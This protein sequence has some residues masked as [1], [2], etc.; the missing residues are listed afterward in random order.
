M[1][2][3]GKFW[4]KLN[5]TFAVWLGFYLYVCAFAFFV[6]LV[7]LPY[8][9]PSLH[10]GNGLMWGGD[11]LNFHDVAVEMHNLVKEKGWSAW[12]LRPGGR[13]AVESGIASA[14]YV[15]FVPKPWV[16]IPFSA[17]FHATSAFL[18]V[19]ILRISLRTSLHFAV[20][21]AL[22]FLL[23]PSS[24]V[25]TAMIHKD[26]A[27]ILGMLLFFYAWIFLHDRFFQTEFGKT[28]IFSL[29]MVGAGIFLC[30][31]ARPYW[32][33]FC[34]ILGFVFGVWTAV[35]AAFR[36]G[37]KE[38]RVG[39]LIVR[40][41]FVAFVA[42]S[43]NY[44]NNNFQLFGRPYPLDY[45]QGEA[46]PVARS[47]A[48]S[49]IKTPDG[50]DPSQA[51][52]LKHPEIRLNDAPIPGV[53]V[54]PSTLLS[55]QDWTETPY[56]P[57]FLE[58]KLYSL[59]GVRDG[60]AR[61]H[62]AGT[63]ID[64]EIKFLCAGDFL[65]YFPRAFEI[66]FFAPFPTHWYGSTTIKS[67]SVLRKIVGLEMASYYLILPFVLLG[68]VV[69]YRKTETWWIFGFVFLITVVYAYSVPNAGA[70][71]RFRYI[72]MT[73]LWGWG[74]GFTMEFFRHYHRIRSNVTIPF[75][76]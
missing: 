49:D 22:P 68:F 18:I 12:V 65:R 73:L 45:V 40:V 52:R 23:L 28:A 39:A 10:A 1:K 13:F 11:W 71:H 35:K 2:F 58:R 43:V 24:A 51:W 57:T 14:L 4:R 37:R 44:F 38:M 9:L 54:R 63:N 67:N 74:L 66:G 69:H 55:E 16:L 26:G 62:T 25:W 6:Q 47:S 50:I 46:A 15:F 59:A 36:A 27:A 5:P 31:V 70:L 20:F 42:W 3:Q 30:M 33:Y 19:L 29:L 32:I 56:L 64:V 34:V 21:G 41:S 48:N 7:L 60:F 75:Y 17:F 53:W 76:T 72:A 8:I 61:D